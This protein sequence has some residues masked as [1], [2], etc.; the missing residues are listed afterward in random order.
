MFFIEQKQVFTSVIQIYIPIQILEMNEINFQIYYTKNT[1]DDEWMW[2][3]ALMDDP[4][5]LSKGD[6]KRSW[7]RQLIIYWYILF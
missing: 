4:S 3:S 2:L 5:S 6:N 1:I 7:E